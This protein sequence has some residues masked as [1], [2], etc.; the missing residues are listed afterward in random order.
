M[1]KNGTPSLTDREEQLSSEEFVWDESGSSNFHYRVLPLLEKVLRERGCQKI[2]DMGCGNGSLT[3]ALMQRGFQIAGI[4]GSLSGIEIARSRW[5]SIAFEKVD[6]SQPL[7]DTYHKQ[8]DAVVSVEVIEHLLLPRNLINN[9]LLAMRPGA[10]LVLTTPYHGYLKNLAIAALNGFDA[11]WHPLR[12]FGHIK[13][14]SKRTLG[15]LLKEFPLTEVRFATVGRIP[16][17]AHSM[18]VTARYEQMDA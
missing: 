13:F 12:D 1:K 16:P 6:I 5:P 18:L 3:G 11:H 14:F 4:D 17:L 15:L 8:F 7:P 10:T 9:A 2:L